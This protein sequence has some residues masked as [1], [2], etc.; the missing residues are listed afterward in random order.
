MT[1]H[2]KLER[3]EAE[4]DAQLLNNRVFFWNWRWVG[5]LARWLAR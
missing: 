2:D 1:L 4:A 5:R 3:D